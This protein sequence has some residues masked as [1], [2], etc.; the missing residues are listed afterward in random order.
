[1]AMAMDQKTA[2][3]LI[4]QLSEDRETY[5]SQLNKTNDLLLQLLNSQSIG[6][7][8]SSN[9]GSS[10]PPS[11]LRLTSEAV[12]RQNTVNVDVETVSKDRNSTMGDADSDDDDEGE[13]IFVKNPLPREEYSM[14][15]LREHL[16]LY[17]WTDCDRLVLEDT[18][19]K[20]D[21][22]NTDNLLPTTPGSVPDRSHLSHYSILNVGPDGAP[23]D[24][25]KTGAGKDQSRAMA[26]WNRLKSINTDPN[27]ERHACGRV[28]IV[29][30]PSPIL[31]AALHYTMNKHF[32]VDEMFQFLVD[33][34]PLLSHPHRPFSEDVRHRRSFVWTMEY[35]TIIDKGCQPMIWQYYERSGDSAEAHVPIGRC[36][37]VVGLS[38]TGDPIGKIKNRDRRATRK[39][40]DVYDPFAPYHVLNIQCYPDVKST[41]DAHTSSKYYVNGPE[42]YLV[43]LRSEIRDCRRRLKEV[44][45][46]I[47]SLVEP[48]S[49]FIF[50]QGI[51]DGMLFEDEHFTYSRRY[52]WAYQTL[53]IMNQDI[54]DIV[55]NF[56][57]SF[58]N[59]VWKGK[60]K[61]IWP[62][63]ETQSSRYAQWR[64]RMAGLKRDM[65]DELRLLNDIQEINSA[66][67]KQITV[68]RD[69]LF[70][71]TSVRESRQSVT[72]SSITVEQGRNIKL[73]TL[74]T[75]FFLPLTFVTSVFGMSAFPNDGDFKHFAWATV[76]VCVPTYLLIG[77]LNTESGLRWWTKQTRAFFGGLGNG[78][79]RFLG[80]FGLHPSWTER[81]NQPGPP[82]AYGGRRRRPRTRTTM[83]ADAVLKARATFNSAPPPP[84]SAR[85]TF[86]RSNSGPVHR[87]NTSEQTMGG[88]A[89]PE[90]P[91]PGTLERSS[92]VRFKLREAEGLPRS[93]TTARDFIESPQMMESPKEMPEM[94]RRESALEKEKKEA[95]TKE[96]RMSTESLSGSILS[97]LFKKNAKEGSARSKSRDDGDGKV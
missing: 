59:D 37:A 29:R 14:E 78:L 8:A 15:G 91:G 16:R 61:I 28:T 82:S 33:D 24:I 74:V 92:T 93:T 60:D 58:K 72:N 48:P 56:K 90:S 36:S 89:E 64:K 97:K 94:E 22:L 71:G 70:S 44:Y 46:N 30:E 68:L 51:R 4:K 79:E 26:I 35:F 25:I 77:S 41:L 80:W 34:A 45:K 96:R 18:M 21:V 13:S 81:R 55:T 87:R 11:S 31:F 63:E 54:Q 69:N 42:A 76:A 57:D 5:L 52:F 49:D 17:P 95:A 67:M 84:P 6:R 88:Y 66:K 65:D 1:M 43:T 83:S 9:N 86:E 32:D 27:P 19:F 23:L 75:I 3:E 85:T 53:S 10:S 47:C 39:I 2:E 40:G 7:I 62:G 50:N 73:L 20:D 12:R 38:L